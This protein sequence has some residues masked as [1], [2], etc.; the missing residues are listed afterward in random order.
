MKL[1]A[2]CLLGAVLAA[3]LRKNTPEFALLLIVAA[4]AAVFF[5]LVGLLGE[6]FAFFR[7]LFRQVSRSCYFYAYAPL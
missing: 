2:L 3:L 6:A 7:Q 4:V 5:S 1:T